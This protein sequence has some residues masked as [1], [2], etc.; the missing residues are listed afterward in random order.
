[1]A[2]VTW[3]KG[4]RVNLK[5]IAD[6]A[7]QTAAEDGFVLPRQGRA[8]SRREDGA[9]GGRL[10]PEL[11]KAGRG[12]DAD[13][14]KVL[15]PMASN[16]PAF[17]LA[18]S[19]TTSTPKLAVHTHGGYQVGVHAL[20]RW[21]MGLEPSNVWWATS[22]IGWIVQ[23]MVY[24]PLL[25]GATTILFEGAI[26]HPGPETFYRILEENVVTGVFVADGRPAAHA[27]RRRGRPALRPVGHHPCRLRRRGAQRPGLGMASTQG[28]QRP[29]PRVI[30]HMW[31]TETGGPV[32]G[33]PYGVQACCPSSPVPRACP[34]RMGSRHRRRRRQ[35]RP[36]GREGSIVITRPFP[37]LTPTIWGDPE[38]YTHDY[39]SR[40]P[41][42]TTRAT[43]PTWTTTA[44]C[45]S[46]GGPTTS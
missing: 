33:N 35:P 19:G 43:P 41:G 11:G 45:G 46:A 27:V 34:S 10:G 42:C 16:D 5:A 25:A 39:W 23:H 38:R 24:A 9:A 26:D 12:E 36:P 37:S 31:Q 4:K 8:P 29:G 15:F 1:M 7:V 44:T 22:D 40:V 18:T 2:D 21:M 20:G 32:V 13:G 14:D 3:R 17:I 30:D 28:V 6:V